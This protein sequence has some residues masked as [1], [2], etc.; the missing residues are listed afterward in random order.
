MIRFVCRNSFKITF[1]LPKGHGN[2]N[3][4]NVNRIFTVCNDRM[5]VF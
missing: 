4:T 3:H 2:G 1:L 5:V